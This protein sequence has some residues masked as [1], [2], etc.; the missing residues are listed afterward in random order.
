[1]MNRLFIRRPGYMAYNVGY[2]ASDEIVTGTDGWADYTW[3]MT[4]GV[5]TYEKDG[6][7]YTVKDNT[8]QGKA[9][10]A[11]V[12]NWKVVSAG[13]PSAST[14]TGTSTSNTSQNQ[15]TDGK[16]WWESA[17]E[18]IIGIWDPIPAYAPT[19]TTPEADS[20]PST[21]NGGATQSGMPSWVLPVS[22][23]GGVSLIGLIV[24]LATR[25]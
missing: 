14:T 21:T 6:K 1:M 20:V 5:I 23:V 7:T 15:E 9:I 22:I 2:G 12:L 3:N 18:G 13:S 11:A 25:K 19:T 24:V 17:A 8:S 4:T 16:S 10:T